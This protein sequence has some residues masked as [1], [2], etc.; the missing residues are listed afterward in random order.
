MPWLLGTAFLHSIMVQEKRG[1]LKVWNATLIVATFS[2]ALLGTF[3]V[4]SGVLQSIHAFGDSTVGPYILG[5]IAVVAI[6]SAA[7]IVSRLDD[8]RSERRIDSLISREAVF[9]INNLLLIALCVAIFW[10]TFFPLISELFTGEKSSLAA[11]WFDRYTTPLAVVLVLFTGIGPLLAWR[12]VSWASA[13]RVFLW[14]VAVGALTGLVL[15]IATSAGESPWALA[16]FA[17]S[18][19]A[20]TGLGQE[21]WRGAAGRRTL[22]G[23]SMPAALVGVVARNRRRY[24]GYIVHV[25]VIVL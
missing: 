16:L 6:G 5:L 4:R 15:L 7:L 18:A 22:A 3:L 11:P 20:L 13:K 2:L 14:P 25:G 9:L 10:G 12:R 24:G 21:F 23:G 19:F 17:F 1:M 8:L